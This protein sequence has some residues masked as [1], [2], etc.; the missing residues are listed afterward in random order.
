MTG[1]VSGRTVAGGTS[2]VSK[3]GFAMSLVDKEG[4]E[5]DLLLVC[6]CE[7]IS[8]RGDSGV[9]AV[10]PALFR[11]SIGISRVLDL[12][13]ELDGDFYFECSSNYFLDNFVFDGCV[14]RSGWCRLVWRCFHSQ[15]GQAC[16]CLELEYHVRG[17][18]GY[19]DWSDQQI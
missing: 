14:I 12:T 8:V 2:G 18:I 3:K 6:V 17:A 16:G 9:A 7:V 13:K 11:R 5:L 4:R 1:A 19:R 15:A 10:L